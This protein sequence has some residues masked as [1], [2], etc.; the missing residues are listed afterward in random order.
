MEQ[1]LMHDGMVDPPVGKNPLMVKREFANQDDTESQKIHDL[2]DAVNRSQSPPEDER[3]TVKRELENQDSASAQKM[4]EMLDAV[5]RGQSTRGDGPSGGV[6][7]RDLE[8]QDVLDTH[9]QTVIAIAIV[10]TAIL[11]HGETVMNV[12]V[13]NAVIVNGRETVN[14]AE[15]L[16]PVVVTG[17]GLLGIPITAKTV[18]LATVE[19]TQ[20]NAQEGAIV[21]P[22]IHPIPNESVVHS[23]SL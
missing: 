17:N 11:L 5:N 13:V 4:Y 6:I 22:M 18:V 23:H 12:V 20:T 7:K 2:L 3:L 10:G 1:R 9:F 19:S 16:S 21:D 15:S 14:E 8:A